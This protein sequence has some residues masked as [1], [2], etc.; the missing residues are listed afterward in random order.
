MGRHTDR[1]RRGRHK[2]KADD[3]YELRRRWVFEK[4][5]LTQAAFSKLEGARL[6]VAPQT[7]EAVVR[8]D[9]WASIW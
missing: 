2:L 5:R 3:V 6:G 7:I 8:R 4:L 1:H 9:S